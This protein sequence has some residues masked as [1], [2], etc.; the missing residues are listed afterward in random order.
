MITEKIAPRAATREA[1]K[2][3]QLGGVNGNNNSAI[4]IVH[5]DS[6]TVAAFELYEA[7]EAIFAQ[8]DHLLAY[9]EEGD[10]TGA[11]RSLLMAESA[12]I[13]AKVAWR[14]FEEAANERRAA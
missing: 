14:I 11:R 12:M 2:C 9:I 1:P 4:R 8:A 7:A 3:V 13:R 5:Q 10:R 6:A